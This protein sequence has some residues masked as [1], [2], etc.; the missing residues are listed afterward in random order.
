MVQS[1]S[2]LVRP[3]I[4]LSMV[5]TRLVLAM[6]L[7]SASA[8]KFPYPADVPDDDVADA[9]TDSRSCAPNVTTCV[10]GKLTA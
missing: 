7:L 6:A 2:R 9:T 4:D 1:R 3:V 10:N 8:C 5:L